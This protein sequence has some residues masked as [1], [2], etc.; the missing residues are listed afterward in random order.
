LTLFKNLFATDFLN[1][2]VTLF[3][4]WFAN[5]VSDRDLAFGNHWPIDNITLFHAPLLINGF[6]GGV[7][8]WNCVRVPHRLL[9][10]VDTILVYIFVNGSAGNGAD[11]NLNGCIYRLA[12][13]VAFLA[14]MLFIDWSASYIVNRNNLFLPNRFA[15]GSSNFLNLLLVAR[16]HDCVLT[17]FIPF[18][19]HGLANNRADFPNAL[20]GDGLTN[21]YSFLTKDGAIDRLVTGFFDLLGYQ[22]VAN[23]VLDFRKAALLLCNACLGIPEGSQMEGINF[24]G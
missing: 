24:L 18:F 4:N 14:N 15:N 8:Y 13:L 17:N 19:N 20:F 5:R 2:S 7:R 11:R 10:R 22:F 3:I 16:L 12:D 9:N 21:R 1:I 6:T 23:P